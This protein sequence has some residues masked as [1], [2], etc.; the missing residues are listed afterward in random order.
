MCQFSVKFQPLF[1][2]MLNTHDG[3]HLHSRTSIVYIT[4]KPQEAFCNG[5]I[6]NLLSL[7]DV[8][9]SC[10]IIV[11]IRFL[12]CLRALKSRLSIANLLG[13]PIRQHACCCYCPTNELPEEDVAQFYQGLFEIA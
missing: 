4:E 1:Q 2:L 13:T 8:P 10:N 7:E 12:I 11:G 5:Y 6:E 9:T 3:Q